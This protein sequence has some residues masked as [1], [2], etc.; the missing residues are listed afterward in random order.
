MIS[1]AAAEVLEVIIHVGHRWS[2]I[3]CHKFFTIYGWVCSHKPTFEFT[4]S[5]QYRD[6]L[7]NDTEESSKPLVMADKYMNR[8]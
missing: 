7:A 6:N 3:I 1:S 5:Q 4:M 8:Q 2:Q